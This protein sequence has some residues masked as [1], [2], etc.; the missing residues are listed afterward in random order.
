MLT[1]S[2]RRRGFLFAAATT[3]ALGLAGCAAPVAAPA[4]EAAAPSGEER[5]F[6][7]WHYEAADSAM[8]IAWDDAI[9]DFQVMHP[10][11]KIEFER[12][13]FE[14]M[15][16]TSKMVLSSNDVPDLMEINKGNAT[17]GL[18]A[19]EGLLT[20]LDEVAKER[21]WDTL[22]APSIQTTARYNEQGIMGTGSLFGIPTYG[23][24]VMVYYNKDIFAANGLEVP[25]T[26]EEFEAV[27]DALVAAGIQPLALGA[28]SRWPQSHNWQE[29]LLYKADRELISN[30]QFLTGDVDFEGEAFN[31]AATKFAEQV[32]KGY[33][34]ENANGI[35]YD[36]ANASF[37]QGDVAMNLTGSWAFGGFSTQI[38]DFDWGIFLMPGKQFT[39]GSG[40]NN[41]VVPANAQNKDLAYDLINLTLQPKSQTV[42]ANAG[43]IPI[44]A[45]LEQITDP[46]I[47]ELN[48]KFAEIVAADGLAYYPDWP[49]PGYMDVLAAGL[50]EIIA[51]SMTPAEF[52]AT[53]AAPYEDYKSTLQ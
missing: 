31:Y 44:N 47:K 35:I 22:L 39:T 36:D 37:V 40:G 29:M 17:A 10:D 15:V 5:V 13:T 2:M 49:V 50:Q 46:M 45:D 33:F 34:G 19:R 11:V 14:Q 51:G 18:Y 4:G 25:T 9:A 1:G 7:I 26:L 38:T 52:N 41:W 8:S 12:K 21:G 48:A 3:L 53:L 42:M 16:E 23:E 28:S 30:F 43:G 27:A 20:N 6:R 32:Q 24:Y